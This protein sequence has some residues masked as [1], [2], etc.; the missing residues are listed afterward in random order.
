[1][2]GVLSDYAKIGILS[3]I[4]LVFIRLFQGIS[5]GGE[6]SGFMTYLMESIPNSKDQHYLDKLLFQ[7]PRLDCS[8][9]F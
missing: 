5:I 8:L 4:A 3:P 1:L 6:T 9:I 7:A 2:I